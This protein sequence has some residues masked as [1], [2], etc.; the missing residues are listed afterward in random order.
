MYISFYAKIP[1]VI[2]RPGIK[3]PI[4]I[5]TKNAVELLNVKRAAC[6]IKLL[7]LTTTGQIKMAYVKIVKKYVTTILIP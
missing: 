7:I 4:G 3:N 2:I 6:L 1:A 5:P